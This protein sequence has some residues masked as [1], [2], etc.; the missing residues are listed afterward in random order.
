MLCFIKDLLLAEFQ[1]TLGEERLRMT[2]LS[3]SCMLCTL[4]MLCLRDNVEANVIAVDTL[5][6]GGRF[7]L[8]AA[9]AVGR[10]VSAALS[11]IFTASL[12]TAVRMFANNKTQ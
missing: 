10:N 1:R 6:P 3:V 9:V 12:V 5:F 4:C 8:H 7:L 11:G 2:F